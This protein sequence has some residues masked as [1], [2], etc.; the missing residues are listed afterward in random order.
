MRGLRISIF[1]TTFIL[2]CVGV[3]MIYSAS[4]VTAWQ[5]TGQSA[6]LLRKQALFVLVGFIAMFGVMALD[7]RA[8]QRAAKPLFLL[9]LL[10][11]AVVL[12]P[13]VA[14]EAGGAKRWLHLGGFNF[15][16]SEL[17]KVTL[18][19]YLADFINRRAA[20]LKDFWKGFVPPVAVLGATVSQLQPIVAYQ[21]GD[22]WAL[23]AGDLQFIYDWEAG[24]WVNL[25][26]GAQIGKVLAVLGQPMRLSLNPQWNLRDIE[27]AVETKIV[28]TA[29]ILAP[30]GG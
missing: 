18:V 15:Q 9:S 29:T 24:Q 4:S 11:L 20:H 7:Y 8:L 10:P 16:P 23:S 27:G 5:Q 19:V 30:T 28:F 21:L 25:P 17:V 26:I 1:V 3:V 13:G 22:G 12:L 2:I 6:Q 14:H